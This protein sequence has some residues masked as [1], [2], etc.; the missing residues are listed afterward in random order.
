MKIQG[1]V[2]FMLLLC[3]ATGSFAQK[4]PLDFKAID[5]W[6]I[7]KGAK[8]TDNGHYMTYSIDNQPK[9]SQTTYLKA[10][11][12]TAWQWAIPGVAFNAISFSPD[13]KYAVYNLPGDTI[14][15]QQLGTNK[16]QILSS[17]SAFQFLPSGKLI[18][19]T[20]SPVALAI[21]NL[22]S[23]EMQSYPG[24][25][26]YTVSAN[27]HQLL[28]QSGNPGDSTQ[29]MSL[30]NIGSGKQRIIWKGRNPSTAIFNNDG[31][32]LAFL[33]TDKNPVNNQIWFYRSGMDMAEL[34]T[35]KEMPGMPVD[36]F[37]I[38]LEGFNANSNRLFFALA[39]QPDDAK[40]V[41]KTGMPDVWNYK[42]GLLLP[43]QQFERQVSSGA[44]L[45]GEVNLDNAYGGLRKIV[46]TRDNALAPDHGNF[47]RFAS[48]YLIFQ[49]GSI[50]ASEARI[51]SNDH[52]PTLF[53]LN[54]DDGTET[55][56]RLPFA[57][58]W[59]QINFNFKL[60]P[61]GKWLLFFNRKEGA[62]YCYDV[63]DDRLQNIT[64]GIKASF[65]DQKYFVNPGP[66]YREPAG[67][68]IAGWIDKDSAVLVYDKNDIWK[69]DLLGKKAPVNLTNGYGR[70]HQLELRIAETMDGNENMDVAENAQLL[71]FG[72]DPETKH[73]GFFKLDM[74]SVRGPEKLIFGP[75]NYYNNTVG[76]EFGYSFLPIKA[77]NTNTWI[78]GRCSAANAPTLYATTGFK[79]LKQLTD[80]QPQ[81][82][83]NWLT[84]EL[85]NW[86]MADGKPSQGIL[87]KPEDFDPTKKYPVIFQF[88]H[89]SSDALNNYPA[90]DYAQGDIDRAY[91]V[92][93]GYLVFCPDIYYTVGEKGESVVKRVVSAAEYLSLTRSYVDSIKMGISG[94]SFA[95]W[96]VN[97]LVTHTRKFAAA[98]EC[99]G[100]SD[101][102]MDYNTVINGH[103][104][105]MDFYW[106]DFAYYAIGATLWQRPDLYIKNSPI[107][108]ADKVATPLL[109]LHNK[110]DAGVP[111][112]QGIELF[113]ALWE[114]HKP[115]WLLQ[116][117][118]NGHGVSGPAAVDYTIR[119]MQFFDHY[120]KGAPAPKW[121]TDGIP[122]WMKD[123]DDG[124]QLEPGKTP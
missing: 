66:E 90:P 10:V 85:V 108:N 56:V 43:A 3:A 112:S 42:S 20:K 52:T 35:D 113:T 67:S 5:T 94:E 47:G 105:K 101:L 37:V 89:H 25:S 118:G 98:N 44:L 93:H 86:T 9:D 111:F 123:I 124:L 55:P 117:D 11:T 2:L 68:D 39:K 87:Y 57:N 54:L 84:T 115:A 14:C 41:I 121:M 109:I 45:I 114:L 99:C 120:L 49:A 88:Y 72:F 80:F 76:A 63:E 34:I 48:S 16:K 17:A 95:G 69:I 38:N 29:T 64:R 65:Y 27:G 19:K 122:P 22:A 91:Y 62:W 73:N 30:L 61:T 4:P 1:I 51:R 92:S 24:V 40:P 83:Y 79:H 6:P 8:I 77:K 106:S 12:G 97:Y 96:E 26:D 71:L 75:Y 60:S 33:A 81:K 103:D 50:V 28:L 32:E 110:A 59:N 74:A 13:S 46:I 119:Q 58:D 7:M 18:Y 21:R 23:S 102:V 100:M 116:Y 82:N 78:I 107:F 31:R 53:R 104:E 70:E 36:M 15:I